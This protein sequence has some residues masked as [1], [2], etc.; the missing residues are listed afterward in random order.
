M[1]PYLE[2]DDV[3][4]DFHEQFCLECRALLVPQL[5]SGYIARVDDHVY[6][7]ELEPPRQLAG[8][9]DDSVAATDTRIETSPA[10]SCGELAMTP[11]ICVVEPSV[12][13]ERSAFLEIRDR[14]N[15]ELITVL[16]LLS[17][18][19]KRPG[20]DREQYLG[21]RSTLLLSSVN[22]VELDLLRGGPRMPVSGLPEC[23]YYALV[24][25]SENRP[26]A[27][28]WSITIRDPL[29]VVPVPLKPGDTVM[30]D[31]RRALDR[32]FAAAG[33]ANYIYG[34]APGTQLSET[35]ARWAREQIDSVPT[36]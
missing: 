30:L 10:A 2:H 35:D 22:L 31:L 28:V 16:E 3:W 8:R 18:S 27:Q 11:T 14:Q 36:A 19:N 7:H 15:R 29:P 20:R 21:K 32:A 12:D 25:A 1:D 9:S 33:Y 34:Q 5:G 17:P 26:Q 24:S 4:H 23:D 6:V 13:L